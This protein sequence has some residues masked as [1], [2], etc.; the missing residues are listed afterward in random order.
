MTTTEQPHAHPDTPNSEDTTLE[1]SISITMPITGMTCAAC[2]FHV[3][4]AL[5]EV[6]GVTN[7]EVNLA[8]ERATVVL[9]P[10]QVNPDD[11]IEAVKG[12]GY[13]AASEVITLSIGGMTCAACVAHVEKALNSVT[14]IV[15]TTVHLATE[16]ASVEY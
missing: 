1:D 14:G 8:T 11:L 9:D 10:S 2:V 15:N 3:G 4:N 5:N 13:G 6:E 12:A 7:A 16:R